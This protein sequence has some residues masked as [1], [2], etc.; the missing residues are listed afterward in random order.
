MSTGDDQKSPSAPPMPAPAERPALTGK[1]T[2]ESVM[3]C[4]SEEEEEAQL[5]DGKD[6]TILNKNEEPKKAVQC[7]ATA[8]E[9]SATLA[10]EPSNEEKQLAESEPDCESCKPNESIMQHVP[11]ERSAEH[12]T[13]QE[14]QT[15]PAIGAVVEK[16]IS[17]QTM[18]LPGVVSFRL[19]DLPEPRERSESMHTEISSLSS[20]AN[21]RAGEQSGI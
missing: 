14:Q 16:D 3:A 4:P 20:V 19:S 11:P 5:E 9:P 21:F 13:G 2:P 10:T 18:S 17:P 1:S 7:V 8:G 15:F 6:T 12:T